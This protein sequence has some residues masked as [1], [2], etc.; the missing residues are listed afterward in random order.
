MLSSMEIRSP[1]KEP[2]IQSKDGVCLRTSL[3]VGEGRVGSSL[4]WSL[5]DSPISHYYFSNNVSSLFITVEIHFLR[6]CHFAGS[7]QMAMAMTYRRLKHSGL[8]Q[9][10]IWM[11]D[12][13][14]IK[15]LTRADRDLLSV[16]CSSFFCR[17][18]CQFVNPW[19][20]LEPWHPS[21]LRQFVKIFTCLLFIMSPGAFRGIR[22][23]STVSVKAVWS[24]KLEE[25]TSFYRITRYSHFMDIF[26][27]VRITTLD[28][29]TIY[30]TM[31]AMRISPFKQ[32]SI[33]GLRWLF[34]FSLD[35]IGYPVSYKEA[36]LKRQVYCPSSP[37][38]TLFGD[39]SRVFWEP[40]LEIPE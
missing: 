20:I 19:N 28:C 39:R 24:V 34:H 17:S 23:S 36:V 27:R 31:A 8:R 30:Q 1:D 10:E 11:L 5:G 4:K 3:S 21:H 12:T 37:F 9:L 35:C 40:R 25:W 7:L 18:I 38:I 13:L 16:S 22:S 29:L 14:E 15:G 6:E 32:Q 2:R 26:D 33:R